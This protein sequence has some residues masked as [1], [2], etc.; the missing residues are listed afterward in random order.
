MHRLYCLYSTEDRFAED[1]DIS[2]DRGK[3]TV[4]GTYV[5]PGEF[6]RELGSP[7]SSD[8]RMEH[9]FK[10]ASAQ[11]PVLLGRQKFS[12]ISL[13]EPALDYLFDETPPADLSIFRLPYGG[14]VLCLVLTFKAD[15][16][17]TVSV[18]RYTTFNWA[19]MKLDG[20]GLDD[21]ALGIPRLREL[22]ETVNIGADIHQVLVA[23]PSLIQF[24]RAHRSRKIEHS[25]DRGLREK[26]E[27]CPADVDGG[28]VRSL[29]VRTTDRVR[30]DFAGV[31]FPVATNRVPGTLAA[32][33]PAVTVLVNQME[34]LEGWIV[35]SGIELTCSLS[36]LRQIRGSVYVVLSEMEKGVRKEQRQE[37]D[38]TV[39]RRRL[40]LLS[41]RL[42]RLELEL[43]F[44]VEAYLDIQFV[45]SAANLAHYHRAAASAMGLVEGAVTTSDLLDRASKAVASRREVVRSA[46]KA[47]DEVRVQRVTVAAGFLSAFAVVS[48]IFFGFF[49]SQASPV[50]QNR[51]SYFSLG[52]FMFYVVLTAL[53]LAISALFFA[54]RKR[55]PI[56]V[57]SQELSSW[58]I[59]P[60]D[61][62]KHHLS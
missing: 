44:G 22:M 34:T 62:K 51:P 58:G 13:G 31:K 27:A 30:P 28:L 48:G 53:L 8:H 24:F 1:D 33:G 5:T 15:L 47:A 10:R 54:I 3:R 37:D 59:V 52:Y 60:E 42:G 36:R 43:A 11:M 61:P 49:S 32:V 2:A 26:F 12:S 46:E 57:D 55:Y 6:M 45:L 14:I 4:P 35:W 16:V 9:A 20:V 56:R 18:M 50:V 40:A 23:D 17:Q 29:A 19:D 7:V 21:A 39:V 41:R 38:Y 25:D